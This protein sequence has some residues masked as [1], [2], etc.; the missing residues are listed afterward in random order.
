MDR[1]NRPK[2]QVEAHLAHRYTMKLMLSPEEI[3][4][5]F[6]HE[7]DEDTPNQKMTKTSTHEQQCLLDQEEEE[8]EAEER[9]SY[10]LGSEK[11]Q[12]VNATQALNEGAAKIVTVDLGLGKTETAVVPNVQPE[13]PT[14]S[15]LPMFTRGQ[16]DRTNIFDTQSGFHETV[17]H[18]N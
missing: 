14:A 9:M 15:A 11:K 5:N 7:D 4:A 17:P 18:W 16:G 12:S 10:L 1:N 3:A 13:I 8:K 6:H 2:P